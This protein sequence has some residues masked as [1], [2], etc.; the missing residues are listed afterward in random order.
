MEVVPAEV[1]PFSQGLALRTVTVLLTRGGEQTEPSKL[2]RMFNE[3]LQLVALFV[4]SYSASYTFL[5]SAVD[6]RWIMLATDET[7]PS[8]AAARYPTITEDVVLEF[9]LNDGTGSVGEPAALDAQVRVEGVPASR[10]V[11]AV[12]RQSDGV[13]RVAG[14]GTTDTAGA[15]TL[16]LRVGAT[17]MIYA[18]CPDSWGVAFQALRE[19]VPGDVIRPTVFR[20]WL[21][22]VTQVGQLPA[23]EPEWWDE[24]LGGS[25]PLGTARAEVRRYFQPQAHGPLPFERL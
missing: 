4:T 24:T 1:I 6:K 25:Q 20:G 8:R 13:W 23:T 15:V 5:A 9:D 16:D 17:G 21:Y 22:L 19:V 2:V 10:E 14:S 18:V 3:T 11:V 7:P 12:E